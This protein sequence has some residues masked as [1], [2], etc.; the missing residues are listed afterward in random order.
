MKEEFD[1]FQSSSKELEMEL[2]YQIKSLEKQNLELSKQLNKLKDDHTDIS[3]SLQIFGFIMIWE[4]FIQSSQT[5]EPSIF[6]WR[7]FLSDFGFKYIFS[8]CRQCAINS[9][10][11]IFEVV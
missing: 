2:E 9:V 6:L 4:S 1:E 3:V 11:T 5:R 8:L 10:I 7:Q